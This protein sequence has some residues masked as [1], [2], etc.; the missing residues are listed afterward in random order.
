[1]RCYFNI[2]SIINMLLKKIDSESTQC[3]EIGKDKDSD[4]LST[5]SAS[6]CSGSRK[7]SETQA[8]ATGGFY[9]RS[10]VTF[11]NE[12]LMLKA[13]RKRPAP[14]PTLRSLCAITR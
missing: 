3:K 9:E 8:N 7:K 2:E 6:G 4:D 1:M 11:E 10:F 12:R 13:F 5:K 14:R